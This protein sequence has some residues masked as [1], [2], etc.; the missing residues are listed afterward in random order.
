[1]SQR[2]HNDERNRKDVLDV[3]S[4][5]S[6]AGSQKGTRSVFADNLANALMSGGAALSPVG[7]SRTTP[8]QN[9]YTSEHLTPIDISIPLHSMG[10]VWRPAA[11]GAGGTH[12]LD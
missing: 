6:V 1:M 8:I 7:H 11:R 9:N 4:H 3:W 2:D 12:T 10:P 5:R